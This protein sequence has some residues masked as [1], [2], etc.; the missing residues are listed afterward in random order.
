MYCAKSEARLAAYF[1]S[2]VLSVCLCSCGPSH[3]EQA[4]VGE[5]SGLAS[6]VL[7]FENVYGY[8]VARVHTNGVPLPGVILSVLM[9]DT[10]SVIARQMNP[11]GIRFL[12]IAEHRYSHGEYLDPWGHP[13]QIVFGGEQAT[14]TMIDGISIDSP[15][16]VWSF[17]KNGKNECGRGDDICSWR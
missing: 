6:A 11:Q 13:Y 15:V 2:L 9:A 4:A 3:Y 7:S 10:N 17:G 5:A 16:A 8:S 12:E 1:R 14:S